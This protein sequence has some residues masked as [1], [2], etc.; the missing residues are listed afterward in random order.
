[1]CAHIYDKLY[2]TKVERAFD[3]LLQL[4][5][6][7]GRSMLSYQM[8][9]DELGV[10]AIG[11]P[12]GPSVVRAIGAL[13]GK[14]VVATYDLRTRP[15]SERETPPNEIAAGIMRRMREAIPDAGW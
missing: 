15:W 10:L 9:E 6:R 14:P 7:Y 11:Q 1:V 4:F 3:P 12:Y 2:A 13:N 8:V 5:I